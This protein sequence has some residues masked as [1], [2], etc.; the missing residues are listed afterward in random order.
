MKS[1]LASHWKKLLGV[2]V[3]IAGVFYPPL[4]PVLGPL[5]GVIVGSDF[6][7]GTQLGTPIGGDAQK[8]VEQVRAVL[9][10]KKGGIIIAGPK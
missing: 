9:P 10:Q 8:L 4:A 3:G 5:G 7:I 1:W 2:A 6:Q